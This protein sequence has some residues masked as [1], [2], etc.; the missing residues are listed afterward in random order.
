L[1]N[2]AIIGD[3][4]NKLKAENV[5]ALA[6]KN[7]NKEMIE[8]GTLKFFTE[9]DLPVYDYKIAQEMVQNNIPSCI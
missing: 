7:S 1:S 4:T 5:Y 2:R 9:L 8:S 6:G 3:I